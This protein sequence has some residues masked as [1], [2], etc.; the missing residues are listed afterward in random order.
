[1]KKFV[2]RNAWG[3][4]TTYDTALKILKISFTCDSFELTPDNR[5]KHSSS[6][7]CL[8]PRGIFNNASLT[9]HANCDDINSVFQQTSTLQL[10]H[11]DSNMCITTF[12]AL[13]NP[14]VGTE[15]IISDKCDNKGERIFKMSPGKTCRYHCCQLAV[16]HE[17]DRF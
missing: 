2:L 10:K 6:G 3:I 5:F 14:P 7:K 17:T 15:L 12:G 13:Y 9:L 8:I 1:M 16:F 4:C 11:V